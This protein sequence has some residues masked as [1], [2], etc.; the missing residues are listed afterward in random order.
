M[1]P[2]LSRVNKIKKWLP[3]LRLFTDRKI[4]FNLIIYSRI[5]INPENLAKI[6][7]V[8]L[9]IIGLTKIVKNK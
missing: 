4:N 7:P 1:S 2:K 9:E 8:D 3:W 6:G 5:C